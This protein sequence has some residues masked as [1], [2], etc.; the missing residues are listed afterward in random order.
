VE[1]GVKRA[2]YLFDSCSTCGEAWQ[3]ARARRYDLCV[4]EY[5]LRD[6]NGARLVAEL[7]KVQ[8]ALR[9]VLISFYD[10]EWISRDVTPV[11]DGFL[12]KPF[13]LLD[14]E[15][16][17]HSMLAAVPSPALFSRLASSLD[18]APAPIIKEGVL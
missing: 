12:K 3:L 16:V 5:H 1:N 11:A 8:A 18:Q 17:I 2:G 6:G 14:F 15:R 13:D 4:V 7:K 9:A 10:F